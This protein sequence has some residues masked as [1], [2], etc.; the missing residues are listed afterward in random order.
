MKG[1][2]IIGLVIAG[3]FLLGLALMV[4]DCE[5]S[6]QRYRCIQNSKQPELC[7]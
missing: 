7:R 5:V 4:H 1:E 2:E 6:D 3:L